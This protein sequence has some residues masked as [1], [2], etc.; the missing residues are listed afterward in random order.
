MKFSRR[1]VTSIFL[2]ITILLFGMLFWPFI[3]KGIIEPISLVTWLLLR[4]FVLSI[5]QRYYWGAI[6]FVVMVLLFRLLLQ[7]QTVT[8]SENYPDSNAAIK[9]IGYWNSL[10]TLT[11]YDSR[12]QETL[13]RELIHLLLSLYASKQRTSTS[14]ILYDALQSGELPLPKHI[15]SFLFF[16][17]PKKSKWSLNEFMKSLR[18]APRKWVR[19]WTGQDIAE[20]YRMIDEILNFMETSMEM[21]NDDGKFT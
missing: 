6:I 9:N 7:D 1:T 12:D 8:Q 2:I 13:K 19:R 11:R 20:H 14:F 18:A 3:L 21:K 4:I 10:F 16:D 5:D 17:E 15:H